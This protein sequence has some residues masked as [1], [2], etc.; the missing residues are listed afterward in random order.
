MAQL[1]ILETT[2][3]HEWLEV[4]GF[5]FIPSFGNHLF[6]CFWLSSTAMP[7]FSP[8]V[9]F[10]FFVRCCFNIWYLHRFKHKNEI[11]HE[12]VVTQWVDPFPAMCSSRFLRRVPS[13]RFLVDSSAWTMHA[14]FV[15]WASGVRLVS[16][17][18]LLPDLARHCCWHWN[19]QL[20]PRFFFFFFFFLQ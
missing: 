10:S 5:A 11:V 17:Y 2:D 14:Y 7:V 20:S 12:I 18:F 15:L 16:L 1:Q 19:F 3:V 9:F 8:V 6:F 13:K 4:H